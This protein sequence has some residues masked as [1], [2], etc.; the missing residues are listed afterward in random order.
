[1]LYDGFI[2]FN[3]L[4][5]LELRLEYLYDV[6]DRFILVE[7]RYTFTNEKKELYFE[8]NKR[9]YEKWDNK[10]IH[11]VVD[12][13]P[14]SCN[15]AWDREHY[16]RNII[17]KGI[18]GADENDIF[19]SGDLDEIPSRS[20]ISRLKKL[21]NRYPEKVVR[22][23]LLNCWYFLNYVDTRTFFDD[24][25]SACKVKTYYASHIIEDC[26]K[27]EYYGE[28]SRFTPM[29]IR[30]IRDVIKLPCAGWHFSY[31]GGIERI[32]KKIQSFSHQ[33]YNNAEF[34]DD[35]R[36][37]TMISSGNDIFGFGI[38]FHSIPVGMLMPYP[39]R[40]N[41]KKYKTWICDYNKIPKKQ[42]VKL[43]IKYLCETAC[44]HS[45]Y[46]M[47]RSIIKKDKM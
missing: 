33:E 32:T 3:E 46:V 27:A 34:L 1:M 30:C 31:M 41:K 17:E 6:V 38:T 10:I 42:L 39:V 16:Q 26:V 7:S 40:K 22:F 2:F 37:K 35:D 20:A 18:A 21:L 4:E 5:L 12:K 44:M 29:A 28:G 9:R 45:L 43:Y 19:M 47:L 11:I 13:F 24:S 15:T 23:E 8:S 14:D 36:I 25:I